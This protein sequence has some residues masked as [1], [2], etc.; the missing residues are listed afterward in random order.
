MR[1]GKA[2][3]TAFLCMK[4]IPI[5][6]VLLTGLFLFSTDNLN[7]SAFDPAQFINAM[8]LVLFA[9]LGFEATTALSSNI[10]NAKQNGPR[11][12]LLSYAI[13][14]LL[15]MLYQ[16]FFYN[17]VGSDLGH[18][19]GFLQA[20][21]L[22]ISRCCGFSSPGTFIQNI[23]NIAIASSALGGAFGIIYSNSRNLYTLA[24]HKHIVNFKTFLK[25]NRFG[26]PFGCILAE[27]ALFLIYLICTH[28]QQVPL[29]QI[30]AFGMTIAYSL[31]V[32][33]LLITVIRD[34]SGNVSPAIPALGLVNCLFF[35][36]SCLKSFYTHGAQSLYLYCS[37][38]CFGICMYLISHYKRL[39]NLQCN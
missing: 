39:T 33:A 18:A 38:L 14:M 4:L 23:C 20:F 31:S 9:A 29:Q 1:T 22:L 19:A 15:N 5:F 26:I 27:G 2:M 21:P 35:L 32:L 8:P 34:R 10:E 25:E 28:A 12:I 30:A 7:A 24:L 13:V 11:A 37:F 16:F 17:V 3:Q 36:I 6:F